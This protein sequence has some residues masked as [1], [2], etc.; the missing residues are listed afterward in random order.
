MTMKKITY[1]VEGMRPYDRHVNQ[2]LSALDLGVDGAFIEDGNLVTVTLKPDATEAQILA[3][4]EALKM[5][6]ESLGWVDV[7]VLVWETK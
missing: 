4:P 1:L 5:A 3:Q 2:I 6:Y 7:E